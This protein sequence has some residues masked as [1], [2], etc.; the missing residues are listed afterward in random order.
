MSQHEDRLRPADATIL[1]YLEAETPDYVPLIASHRGLNLSYA[2]RRTEALEERGLVEPVSAEVVYRITGEGE[3]ALES[4]RE[5]S[6]DAE[7]LPVPGD[8]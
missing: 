2:R 3:E 8:D 1:E 5:A 7:D 6:N 4:Y